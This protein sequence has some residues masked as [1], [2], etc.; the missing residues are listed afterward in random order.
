MSFK[1]NAMIYLKL[2]PYCCLAILNPLVRVLKLYENFVL[3]DEKVCDAASIK[4][5]HCALAQRRAQLEDEL[6]RKLQALRSVCLEEFVSLGRKSSRLLK[7]IVILVFIFM[8]I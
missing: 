8:L 7:T 5:A 1:Y 3:V 2:I 4:R 6:R